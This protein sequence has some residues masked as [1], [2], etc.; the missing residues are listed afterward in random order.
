MHIISGLKKRCLG[1]AVAGEPATGE[2]PSIP[3]A[4]KPTAKEMREMETQAG[5]EQERDL[6]ENFLLL[7]LKKNCCYR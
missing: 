5:E 1:P 2:A 6:R 4:K 3:V 7:P